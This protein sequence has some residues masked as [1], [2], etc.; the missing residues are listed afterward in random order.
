MKSSPLL[1][2]SAL[3]IVALLWGF[4]FIPQ[5]LGLETLEPMAFN[6]WRFCF[7]ALTLLPILFFL[8][9]KIDEVVN[10]NVVLVGLL[11]GSMLTAA[12]G[13]QQISLGMTK[14]ANV[15]FITGFY[16]IFVPLFG[17]FFNHRYTMLTWGGGVLALI[18]L[19]LLS[20]FQLDSFLDGSITQELEG[21]GYA[22][23]GAFFWA[24]H[25]LAINYF[26]DRYNQYALAFFQFLFCA[27]LSLIANLMYEPS[28]L[29]T[30][31]S[32]YVW[33]LINGVIVVGIA[34]TLQVLALKHA[35]PF[36][37]SVIFSLESVFGAIAGYWFFQ[38]ALGV[39]GLIGAGLMLVGCVFAQAPEK[40][41]PI[42]TAAERKT[43]ERKSLERK[44]P[45]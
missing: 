1:L 7:G 14:V 24:L 12:A 40:E 25:L 8:R 11:L 28:L 17:L 39:S 37:A 2:N 13:F 32:G 29:A 41:T 22:L 21:D 44:T 19:G 34:Y 9:H 33:A 36:V 30:D 5:K 35:D 23:V 18:G 4:G 26:V 38:E 20:G 3:L 6:A 45:L 42:R 27:L 15:A 10:V 16:V 31:S 43:L